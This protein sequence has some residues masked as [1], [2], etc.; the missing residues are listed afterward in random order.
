MPK[1][2]EIEPSF[3]PVADPERQTPDL[4][5]ACENISP[6]LLGWRLLPVPEPSGSPEYVHI[7][8]GGA[9]K[10]YNEEY[11]ELF[12]FASL[13]N[14]AWEA[15][16]L[17]TEVFDPDDAPQKLQWL[18]RH[19]DIDFRLVPAESASSYAAYEPLYHLLTLTTLERFGLPPLKKG[20]WPSL[21][22]PWTHATQEHLPNDFVQRL[23][24]AFSFQLWPL[25]NLGRKSAFSHDEPLTTLSHSLDFWLPYLDQ[26]AQARMRQFPRVRHEPDTLEVLSG[27]PAAMQDKFHRPLMGGSIW[28]GEDDAN[29]AMHEMVELADA[30]GRLRG[31]IDAVRSN[32][33]EDDFSPRWSLAKEDF[34]RKIYHK[35]NK[36]KISFV[37]MSD[38]IP[39]HGPDAEPDGNLLWQDLLTLCNSKER[40]IVVC[41]RNGTTR[42]TDIAQELGYANHSAVSKSLGKIRSKARD[43]LDL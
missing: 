29:E 43:L 28:L 3:S 22:A 39:F 14:S 21:G 19:K 11:A 24:K 20:H 37:E 18:W 5:P 23:G 40:L 6:G 32:R 27:L 35:R 10:L 9:T 7:P 12:L 16:H 30:S 33:V 1:T 42:A 17:R 26:V 41:L 13:W 31:L 15:G 38:T 4:Y 8:A 36:V 2:P 34:E 25:L